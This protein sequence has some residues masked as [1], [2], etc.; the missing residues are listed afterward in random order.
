MNNLS[1]FASKCL[2]FIVLFG[3]IDLFLLVILLIKCI[4]E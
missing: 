2:G 1:P 4:A 3:A